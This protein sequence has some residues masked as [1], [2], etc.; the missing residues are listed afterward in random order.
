[1][2]SSATLSQQFSGISVLESPSLRDLLLNWPQ[3]LHLNWIDNSPQA[4][5][6][7]MIKN[8]PAVASCK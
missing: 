1:M 8:S 3:S 2:D 6:P 7:L 5:N 4:Y